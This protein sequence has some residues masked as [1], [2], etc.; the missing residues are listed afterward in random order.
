MSQAKTV[1]SIELGRLLTT[2]RINAANLIVYVMT[3]GQRVLHEGVFQNG[4][5]MDW[6]RAFSCTPKLYAQ[7]TTE[8]EIC[9]VVRTS[10]KVRV[11]GAGH[12]F[13]AG[14]LTDATLISLDK[15]NK[16]EI[17]ENPDKPGYKIAKA[18]AG[19]RLRDLTRILWDAGLSISIGGSTD[20]Q[21]IGGLLATDVHGTGRDHGFV[22][23]SILSLRVVDASGSAK[24]FGRNDDVFHAAIGGAG[25]CGVIIGVEMEC[26][27]AYQL[28]KAVKVVDREWAEDNIEALL[29][30]NTHL[31]FYYFAG[32]ARTFEQ[33]TVEGLNKIRMNKWNRTVEPPDV[34]RT[35]NEIVS[36]AADLVFSGFLF[37]AARFLHRSD[38]LAR[39]SLQ[40]YALVVNQRQA[41]YPSSEGFPRKLYYRHDELE[42]GVP[43]EN[44]RECLRE[45]RRLLIDRQFPLI[46]EVRFTP[47]KSQAFLGPGTGRRS[48]YLEIT[49]SMSRASDPM[50]M[51][52][53]QIILRHGGQAHLGKKSYID[54]QTFERMYSRT[55]HQ[56]HA[57]RKAQDPDGKFLNEF[58]G[59]LLS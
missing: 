44:Y 15:Y 59:R 31:S 48:V 53:E 52:V 22:S 16:V 26:E 3:W 27:P 42:Y 5:W 17:R 47:D 1:S 21:S 58:V 51:D 23:E 37:D 43:F 41:V 6:A 33:E 55:I 40:V 9:E 2:W 54:R 38:T 8:M 39:I 36:E 46:I 34:F 30:E 29:R 28:A 50:F 32:F 35:F 24:T 20:A 10:S 12:S 49:P 56:F 25:T 45:V 13:N 11:T 57:A 7:P 14:V 4:R 19:I 18:Q